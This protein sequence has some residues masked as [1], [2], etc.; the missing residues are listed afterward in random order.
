[1]V[2]YPETSNTRIKKRNKQLNKGDWH[3]WLVP[4]GG[5]GVRRKLMLATFG[6]YCVRVLKLNLYTFSPRTLR[7]NKKKLRLP[8]LESPSSFSMPTKKM[9]IVK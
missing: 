5:W 2:S 3:I 4:P 1:M 6:I 7:G 8:I 9:L